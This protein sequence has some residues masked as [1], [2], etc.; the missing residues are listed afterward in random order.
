MDNAT[1]PER[2]TALA[3]NTPSTYTP[4]ETPTP[5]LADPYNETEP[6][7][8]VFEPQSGT[9]TATAAPAP[10]MTKLSPI[11]DQIGFDE[12]AK[13]VASGGA[14]ATGFGGVVAA[15]ANSNTQS[16][17][18]ATSATAGATE[19]SRKRSMAEESLASLGGGH[20]GRGES[21]GASESGSLLSRLM[22]GGKDETIEGFNGAQLANLASGEKA[23]AAK[24]KTPNIFEYTSYRIKKTRKEG[25][26][27]GGKVASLST[28]AKNVALVK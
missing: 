6:S 28:S 19:S 10:G 8:D 5:Q 23:G 2:E 15:A 18:P 7:T 27:K 12:S 16:G 14:A 13:Q 22:G 24:S 25:D 9:L 17:G 26:L 4:A 1:T 11:G 20:E 21:E 3:Q